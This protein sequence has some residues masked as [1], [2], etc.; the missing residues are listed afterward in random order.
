[1]CSLSVETP[2]SSGYPRPRFSARAS[3]PAL[4]CPPPAR[5]PARPPPQPLQF[6][7]P[8]LVFPARTCSPALPLP[9]P[10]LPQFFWQTKNDEL[11]LNIFGADMDHC[12]EAA[13]PAGGFT[14][15]QKLMFY[16]CHGYPLLP[17]SPLS[18]SPREF[19]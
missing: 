17:F 6:P 1:M 13:I 11:R 4:L 9:P 5:P 8:P 16:G 2:N 15:P 18:K 3:P 12:L 14:T 10:L 7:L 19:N